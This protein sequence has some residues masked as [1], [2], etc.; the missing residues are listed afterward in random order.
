MK[1]KIEERKK[2]N[3]GKSRVVVQV[4]KLK[5]GVMERK[6]VTTSATYPVNIFLSIAK[7]RN[8]K[9]NPAIVR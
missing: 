4:N 9:Q 1:R 7:K 5:T 2:M 8:K 3:A 6:N